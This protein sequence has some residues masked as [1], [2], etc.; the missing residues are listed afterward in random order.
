MAGTVDLVLRCYTGLETRGGVLCLHPPLPNELRALHAEIL[1]RGLW[2]VIDVDHRVL[3]LGFRPSLEPP[4]KIKLNGVDHM[5]RAG[6]QP[7][8]RLPPVG[9]APVSA[10]DASGRG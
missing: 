10:A 2:M 7:S 6:T 5:L 3:R 1:Y 4:I 8:F 9:T